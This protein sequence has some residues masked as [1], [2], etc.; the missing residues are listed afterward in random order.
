VETQHALKHFIAAGSLALGA[1]G[2]VKPRVPA[3]WTGAAEPEARGL[4]FRDLAVG[5]A[6][7][8]NPRLGL[9]QRAIVDVGDAIVFARRKPAVVAVAL[10]SAALAVYARTRI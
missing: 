8:A 7:Y 1:V 5:I 9:A 2:I 3:E 6:V 10:G 4:G